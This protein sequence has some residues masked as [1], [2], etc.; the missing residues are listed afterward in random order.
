MLPAMV[1]TLLLGA[2]LAGCYANGGMG[3]DYGVAYSAPAP[4]LVYVSPDVQV[5]ADYDYPVFYSSNAYWRYDNGLWYRSG[6]YDGGWVVDYNVPYAVAHIDRPHTYVHYR[7]NGY[8]GGNGGYRNNG[9]RNG[10]NERDHRTY[11]R[12][13][14]YER[15]RP[16]GG[17]RGPAVRDHRHR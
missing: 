9:Y 8:Y 7:G 16:W 10:Y 13:A 11:S 3:M 1:R 6:G 15:A 12:P 5:V 2:L 14:T 17:S 4:A